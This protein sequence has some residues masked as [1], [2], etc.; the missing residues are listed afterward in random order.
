MSHSPHGEC[1][2]KCCL[3]R[4]GG[5]GSGSLPS[6][7]VWIEI[8][9]S[10]LRDSF[11]LRHSPHGECGLKLFLYY[12]KYMNLVSLPSRGVWIEIVCGGIKLPPGGVTPLTGSVD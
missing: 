1:G 10:D 3:A 9:P 5:S 4:Y 6:R 12:I 11:A 2:L 7:G 8:M